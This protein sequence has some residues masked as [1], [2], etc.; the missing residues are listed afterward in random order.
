MKKSSM[1]S[2]AGI[3]IAAFATLMGLI[4]LSEAKAASFD[5]TEVDQGKFIAVA[6]PIG[7]GTTH[8]LLLIEQVSDKQPCWSENGSNPVIVE[9][10]LT[11]FDF[12]GICGRSVDA[13]GYSIRVGGQD[14]GLNYRL[15]IR[16]REGNMFLVGVPDTSGAQE[17]VLGSTGGM[18]QGFAK[19]N[20]NSGWRLTKRSFNSK[21]LGHVYLTA[22][23]FESVG[24]TPVDTGGGPVGSLPFRDVAGD[25]YL[26][27]I[28]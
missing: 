4:P 7:D 15:R 20:F 8:Q 5:Q 13:N 9:P 1:R 28:H 27:E 23:S 16:K 22:D 26:A 18:T 12:T 19:I 14:M 21:T 2:P 10:L 11:K 24:S 3:A 6:A 25:T 17:V